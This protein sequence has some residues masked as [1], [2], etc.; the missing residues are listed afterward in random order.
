MKV[1]ILDPACVDDNK[2]G[3]PVHIIAEA[4]VDTLAELSPILIEHH[5]SIA[6]FRS[7]RRRGSDW[8]ENDFFAVDFDDGQTAKSIHEFLID[9]NLNHLIMAS[10][11]HQRPKGDRPPIDRFHVFIPFDQPIRVAEDFYRYVAK[12][13]CQ[14]WRWAV[15]QAATG[16]KVRYY[17]RHREQ[18]YLYENGQPLYLANYQRAFLMHIKREREEAAKRIPAPTPTLL[19]IKYSNYW[20]RLAVDLRTHGFRHNTARKAALFMFGL[21]VDEFDIKDMIL[22]ASG[23]SKS[24]DIA[25][26]TRVIEWAKKV[27][28]K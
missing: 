16:D 5:I 13:L 9:K 23:L 22:E 24:A 6:S 26:L 11:N 18:L 10:K 17:Y 14:Q 15:D 25:D 12:Q 3:F 7:T 2:G 20:R 19:R 27:S 28:N 8:V 21:G 1:S 4:V